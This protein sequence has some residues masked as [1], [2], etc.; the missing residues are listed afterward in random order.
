MSEALRH[1]NYKELAQFC[2][3]WNDDLRDNTGKIKDAF[4]MLSPTVTYAL[5]QFMME[6]TDYG[7]GLSNMDAKTWFNDDYRGPLSDALATIYERYQ[8]DGETEQSA[9][10]PIEAEL[11]KMQATLKE[12]SDKLAAVTETDKPAEP[13]ADAEKKDDEAESE[14][15]KKDDE[16]ETSKE[17]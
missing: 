2:R 17:E 3:D 14:E 15:E 4:K 8:S 5:R 13:E 11:A 6:V 10:N 1:K 7:L 16:E 12:M 9:P